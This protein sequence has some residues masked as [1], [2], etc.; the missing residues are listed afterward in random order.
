GKEITEYGDH[1]PGATNVFRA[2]GRGVGLLAVFADVFK[3]TPLII[4]AHYYLGLPEPV[5]YAV[6]LSAVLGHMYSPFLG[7]HGGKA[8]A[9]TI[10][11]LLVLPQPDV[12]VV[13]ILLMAVIFLFVE[14]ESDAW[15][16]MLSGVGTLAYVV[17]TGK[18]FWM[19]L[20]VVCLL[21]ALGKRH[22]RGLCEA[23]RVRFKPAGWIR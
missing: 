14:M 18:G 16:V 23:P 10:G 21:I 15:E 3:G 9:T 1:N 8:T 7:F 2:G 17:F 12:F 11:V 4:L 22:F 13:F 19:Y 20:F 6:A 5:L